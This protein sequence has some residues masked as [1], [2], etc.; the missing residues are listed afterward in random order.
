MI[1]YVAGR[2][3]GMFVMHCGKRERA[4]ACKRERERVCKRERVRASKRKRD[5]V[6]VCVC[7]RERER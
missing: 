2:I 6:H 5:R 4:R 3:L 1:F 7:V